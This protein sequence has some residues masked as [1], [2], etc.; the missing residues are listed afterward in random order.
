MSKYISRVSWA[1]I[2]LVVSSSLLQAATTKSTKSRLQ[3]NRSAPATKE[4]KVN[5]ISAW[6]EAKKNGYKFYPYRTTGNKTGSGENGHATFLVRSDKKTC[7]GR[8]AQMVGGVNMLLH[9]CHV[10][11]LRKDGYSYF[12]LFQGKM[13]KRGW[14]IKSMKISGSYQWTSKKWRANTGQISTSIKVNS[15]RQQSGV[16]KAQLKEIV[17]IG[18]ANG[19]WTDAFSAM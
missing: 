6:S 9:P 5:G 17:L 4:F 7:A 13:L 1:V 10:A 15:S 18:P 12:Y 3:T 16:S 11:G 14:K 8:P 2:M 19:K